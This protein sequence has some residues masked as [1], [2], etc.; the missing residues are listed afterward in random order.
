[1]GERDVRQAV[2]RR[3]SAAGLRRVRGTGVV[4]ELG[5]LEDD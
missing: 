2:S 5:V 3:K 4:D 1:V